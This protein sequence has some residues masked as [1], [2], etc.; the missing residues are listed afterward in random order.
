MAFAA[1]SPSPP[2]QCGIIRTIVIAMKATAH[3]I[4]A[5]LIERTPDPWR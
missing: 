4:S 1:A 5:L 2:N 3:S